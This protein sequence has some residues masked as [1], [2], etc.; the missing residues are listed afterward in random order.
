MQNSLALI[1]QR[2]TV[3]ELPRGW[4]MNYVPDKEL[5]YFQVV[6]TVYVGIEHFSSEWI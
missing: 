2:V 4:Y 5:Q 1:Q 6:S 3:N